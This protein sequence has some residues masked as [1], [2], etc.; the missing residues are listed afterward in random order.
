LF[1][2]KQV[3]CNISWINFNN[4]N[5]KVKFQVKISK[6]EN[7]TELIKLIQEETNK[8]YHIK[9]NVIVY[10]K[11][12]KV[13]EDEIIGNILNKQNQII[14]LNLTDGNIDNQNRSNE[15]NIIDFEVILIPFENEEDINIEEM[16]A[17][18]P[19]IKNENNKVSNMKEYNISK[20][21]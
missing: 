11:G 9:E 18:L 20:K 19:N 2:K 7:I 13:H 8:L 14:D 5:E 15:I 6:S 17:N 1:S 16:T 4:N 3:I 12:I 21:L 10:Y